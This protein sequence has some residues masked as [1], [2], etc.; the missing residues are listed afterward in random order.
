MYNYRQVAM[1]MLKVT[2]L[3]DNNTLI[4]RYFTGEP[5]FCLWVEAGAKK[6]LF[7]TGYSD[8]FIRNAQLMGL[9]PAELD[10]IFL[11][12]GHNDH[13]WGLN[14]LIQYYDRRQ[15]K[16][17][18]ELT[19]HHQALE[20][21]RSDGLEIGMVM[22]K[23]V[24]DKYFLM[25]LSSGPM[26]ITERL[27][28]L[29]EIPRRI[30]KNKAIGKRIM[31]GKEF[32]DF[33]HDDSALVYEANGGLVILTGCSHSGICNIIEYARRLTG[34]DKILDVLG[35]FHMLDMTREAM[36]AT[37]EY[38][39]KDPPEVIHPCHCTDLKAKMALASKIS[40]EEVGVGLELQYE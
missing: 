34:T 27:L 14:H 17:R 32:D 36:A 20:R 22:A 13:T 10:A 23:E 26:R 5:G 28:W 2:V 7:D 16:K 19:A 9:D 35:G 15:I 3:V 37:V 1:S 11:S 29:G 21:K 30:E 40:V 12:H 33:C 18:P 25:K 24:I 39:A 4:D 8:V 6:I 38:L 31:D